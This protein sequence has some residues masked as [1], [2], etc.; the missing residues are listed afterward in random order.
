LASSVPWELHLRDSVSGDLLRALP[1]IT[2]LVM[3]W[4][5]RR[6]VPNLVM[7]SVVLLS[8]LATSMAIRLVFEGG[9]Y[10]YYFMASA[11]SIILLDFVRRTFRPEV[12]LW[13]AV[14]ALVFKPVPWGIDHLTYGVPMWVW[15]VLLVPPTVALAIAP[16]LGKLRAQRSGA[17]LVVAAS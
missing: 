8:L 6:R 3:A 9:L 5:V 14:E 2:V 12:I 4:L 16:L 17:P 11:V 10:G 7:E 1:V 15:Q 13:L